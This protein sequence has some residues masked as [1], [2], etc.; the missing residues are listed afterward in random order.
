[1]ASDLGGMEHVVMQNA[2]SMWWPITAGV[3][4]GSVLG[5]LLLLLYIS[6]LFDGI[7]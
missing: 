3:P 1:M 7:E 5:P 2:D 6:E 4:Q